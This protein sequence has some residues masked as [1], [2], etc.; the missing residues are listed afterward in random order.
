MTLSEFGKL[1]PKF[2]ER[3]VQDYHPLAK[4]DGSLWE[5]EEDEWWEELVGHFYFIRQ[6]GSNTIS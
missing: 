1:A 5:M 6:G 3:F 2:V 4:E